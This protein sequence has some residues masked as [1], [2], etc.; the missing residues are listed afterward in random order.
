MAGGDGADAREDLT[1]DQQPQRRLHGA[2]DD[3]GGVVAQLAHLQLGDGQR[4][5]EK[6]S[7]AALRWLR[8]S[9]RPGVKSGAKLSRSP[10]R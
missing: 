7:G 5:A 10:S 3:V 8:R 4:L 9:R 1:K 2:R 6:A